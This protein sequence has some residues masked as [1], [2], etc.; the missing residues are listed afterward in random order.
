MDR[1]RL[2]KVFLRQE[3]NRKLAGG[4]KEVRRSATGYLL[5]Q[6]LRPPKAERDLDTCLGFVGAADLGERIV[7]AGGREDQ[8]ARPP[9]RR[10]GTTQEQ[11]D[12]QGNACGSEKQAWAGTSFP[13]RHAYPLRIGD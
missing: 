5:R 9:P 6:G 2:D 8:R 1:V 7:Q 3:F 12:G 11:S 10:R 4:N 13:F